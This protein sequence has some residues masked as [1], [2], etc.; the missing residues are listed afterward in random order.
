ML[1]PDIG[2]EPPYGGSRIRFTVVS[3][4]DESSWDVSDFGCM[5][6]G[7]QKHRMGSLC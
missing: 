4:A 3:D 1:T 2:L 5:W 7:L 6:L